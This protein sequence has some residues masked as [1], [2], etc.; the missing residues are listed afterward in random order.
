MSTWGNRGVPNSVRNRIFERDRNVCQL[1]DFGC[2][3]TAAEVDHITN[4]AS[5]SM[6]R[7]NANANDD[8]LQAVCFSCHRRKSERERLA[9]IATSTARRRLPAQSHPGDF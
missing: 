6:Q 4:L 1:R 7:A 8:Q 2:H 5:L 9:G 3:V